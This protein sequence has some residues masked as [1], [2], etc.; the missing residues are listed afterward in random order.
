M[1][2]YLIQTRRKPTTNSSEA[3]SSE[4][5]AA[6]SHN[7]EAAKVNQPKSETVSEKSDVSII[8]VSSDESSAT[9][10][11]KSMAKR[12]RVKR[13]KGEVHSGNFAVGPIASR[14]RSRQKK[15]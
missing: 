15:A 2:H 11:G 4:T 1:A 6:M 3:P 14:L 12:R 7:M 9:D 13:E 8:A 5:E 10:D